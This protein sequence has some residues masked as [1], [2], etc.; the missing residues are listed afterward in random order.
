MRVT[1]NMRGMQM[2]DMLTTSLHNYTEAVKKA[3]AQQTLTSP[4]EDTNKYIGAFNVQNTIDELTQFSENA[5]S[6][7][8]WLNT[9]DAQLKQLIDALKKARNDYAVAGSSDQYDAQARKA[10]AKDVESLYKQ[11]LDIANA[12]NMGRFIFG[13]HT[14]STPPFSR[15]QSQAVNVITKNENGESLFGDAVIK[16]VFTDMT[17]LKSGRY[18]AEITVDGDIATLR[19]FDENGNKVIIDTNGSDE[20]NAKGNNTSTEVTFPYEP[21]KVI[22]TGRGISF[23]MPN[24]LKN[25][26]SVY[27]EFDYKS[28]SQV[29][30]KGDNGTINTQIGYTQDIT[31]NTPGSNIF[32]PSGMILQGNKLN[33][34]NGLPL[35]LNTIFSQIDNMNVGSGDSIKV[36]GLDHNGNKIGTANV[37]SPSVPDL[38]L[39]T[40]REK[41]R[42]LHVAYGEKLYKIVIPRQ[43]YK[44]M[45]DLTTAINEEMKR[46]EYVGTL[47]KINNTSDVVT[48]E[49]Y[50][51][52]VKNEVNSNKYPG[53][54][55]EGEKNNLRVDLSSEIRIKPDGSRL[56]FVSTKSG[57]NVR[58]AVTGNDQ[59]MLGF[60]N[61]AM[62]SFGKDTTFE[63]G[64]DFHV[65]GAT[66]I[67]TT[68]TGINTNVDRLSF[69]INGKEVN[70]NLPQKNQT[71]LNLNNVDFT[72]PFTF[73]IDG[74]K[75]NVTDKDLNELPAQATLNDIRNLLNKKIDEVGL[76]G[77]VA[78]ENLALNGGG[79]AYNITLTNQTPSK[80]AIEFAIDQALREAGFDHEVGVRLNGSSFDAVNIGQYDITFELTNYNRDRDTKLQSA[81]AR[82]L[83][84]VPITYDFQ[85][86]DISKEGLGQHT[87]KTI[88]D[89]VKFLENLYDH[90][91]DVSLKDGKLTIEDLRSGES[92]LSFRQNAYNQG[93]SHAMDAITN[94][95]GAYTGHRDDTWNFSVTT[96]LDAANNRNVNIVITDKNGNLIYNE[97]TPNYKGGPIELPR[98]LVIHPDDMNIPR[99]ENGVTINSGE[100][101]FSIDLKAEPALS[102]GDMNVVQT[103]KNVNV[104]TALDNLIHALEH[105]VSKN[106]VSEPSAWKDTNL[107]SSA[108][109]FLDGTF[110]GNFNDNWNYEIM[111]NKEK[112]DF[113]I[114]NEF[115]NTTGE[116][117]YNDELKGKDLSFSID[118]FNN[119]TK[120]QERVDI[121]L[122]IPTSVNN[123]KDLQNFI[124][125]ELNNNDDLV[126]HGVRFIEKEGKIEILS[127]SGTKI[128]NF[129][130]SATNPDNKSAAEFVFGFDRITNKKMEEK[131]SIPAGQDKEL[132][133]HISDP[134]APAGQGRLKE[135]TVTIPDPG[136]DAIEMTKEQ[137]IE[138]INTQLAKANG[139]AGGGTDGRVK[140][141]IDKNGAIQFTTDK[142]IPVTA[143]IPAG[144]VDNPANNPLGLQNTLTGNPLVANAFVSKGVQVPKTDLSESEDSARTLKFT[145]TSGNP[146]KQATTSITLDKKKYENVQEL[147]DAINEKL[148][149][150]GVTNNNLKAVVT[151]D[152]SIGYVSANNVANTRFQSV[153]VEGD[154]TG[155]LGYPKAGDS[156][157]VK[158]TNAKGELVQTMD[159]NTAN[160][161]SFV[162][163]GIYLGFNAGTLNATD[164]FQAAVGSGVETE[165]DTLD[166]ALNQV[167]NAATLVGTRGQ[168]VDSVLKFQ[169]TMIKTNQET[170]AGYLGAT[171]T[172][173][174][175][176]STDLELSKTAYQSA[177]S[178]TASMMRISIL[179]FLS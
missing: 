12:S 173:V 172:D 84:A 175:K 148:T 122:N 4:W 3:N 92:K 39:S 37:L 19:L 7:K 22:N 139:V 120:Q 81:F 52:F 42:T 32:T 5:S 114:Q 70:V 24:D 102:F 67:T 87:E 126:K 74:I 75:I 134:L 159:M 161:S 144:D 121:N 63:V 69:M 66:S 158:V 133:F 54:A 116:I 56:G 30:Y 21:G 137:M 65:E 164:N 13:G 174:I 150:K 127:G 136:P 129:V 166:Q 89:Y 62:A 27:M 109:P 15:E 2:K 29:T 78:I 72:N 91:I 23:K 11:I 108:K 94:V 112:N 88:G 131:F 55:T 71:T 145:Y 90:S 76:K 68:H 97:T 132:K 61:Q 118:V 49:A 155:T 43:S 135:I 53:A 160:K 6:A 31:I 151:S 50:A 10:L 179:D 104:F 153:V 59:S 106:G 147:A 125:K 80:K 18:K 26:T 40:A 95:S 44:T 119:E 99:I 73:E 101:K 58:I 111:A 93:I 82:D 123:E 45:E 85:T 103:G 124:L 143:Y 115:K 16:D 34:S 64:Y 57:D 33:T 128:A 138:A 86:A 110:R 14:T 48:P 176:L 157:K 140:A 105:N 41:E 38:D 20:S 168:R 107:K 100:T 163:D 113:F 152:G 36:D 77:Q 156:V 177:M 146:A 117:R 98:G 142:D 170:K 8:N 79:P 1:F 162:S 47:P 17:E 171:P 154:E 141:S 35:S 165:I 149:A 28:G 169:E 51:A 96:N 83:A 9:T 25:T 178:I 46:A 60:K 130:N 167:L